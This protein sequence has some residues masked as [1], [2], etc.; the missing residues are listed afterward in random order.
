MS[1]IPLVALDSQPLPEPKSI[2]TSA[3]QAGQV[4]G[5]GI[6][7]QTNQVDLQQK[8][9]ALKD[10]ET[11]RDLMPQFVKKD[12]GRPGGYDFDGLIQAAQGKVMP[13]TLFSLQKQQS[14]MRQSA[15]TATKD[16]IANQDLL[17]KNL[18]Q[19]VEGLRGLTDPNDRQQ[20]Y[21]NTIMYAQQNHIPTN[22]WPAQAPSDQQLSSVEAELGMHAQAL[23]DAKTQ[24]ETSE[25]TGKGLA[26]RYKEVNGQLMD[27]GAQGG[28]KPVNASA[29]NPDD[30]SK[31]V[32]STIPPSVDHQANMAAH[33][34]VDFYIKQGNIKAAQ[35]VITKASEHAG[36]ISNETNPAIQNAKLQ[37]AVR[38]KRAEQVIAQ[39]DP[40]AAGK[41]LADGSLT[42]SELKSRGTTPDFIVQAT[43]AAQQASPGWNAQ[44][45]DADF[46][47][48]SSPAQVAFFGS[49][50]S[51][52]DP[53][54]TLDQLEAAAKDIPDGKIPVFNSIADAYKA[55]TGSGPV[56]KYAS[57]LVGVSDDYSKVMGGGTGSDSSRSQ[58]LKLVPTNAS[59]EA[60]AAAIEGIRGAVGSQIKSR[61]G[62]NTVLQNM[63]GEGQN[64]AQ[65]TALSVK[66][67]NGKTYNFKDQQSLDNFK[68]EA[69]IQ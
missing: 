18:Y 59:P 2:L 26:E 24:A 21:Q 20:H 28:P 45:A 12:N 3:A 16:E 49:A 61:I 37:L 65:G 23:A 63:Y 48:A 29:L 8:Q 31:L 69:G 46:K 6:Q 33:A 27:L 50:K 67:P 30:W 14:D 36:Q 42:L 41:L 47:V 35:D 32:D 7:N 22:D 44:K 25:A 1:S 55:A 43:N 34:D 56:A 57:I 9:L 10:Q 15:A 39:G 11:L 52:T 54:G 13:E 53:G 40:A 64:S 51:L 66:A 38:T 19:R 60:R 68:K 58:A 17:N 4:Q 62:K 5:Q